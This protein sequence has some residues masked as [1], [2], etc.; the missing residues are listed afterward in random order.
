MNK[1]TS[2]QEWMIH[3]INIHGTFFERWCQ[4]IIGDIRPWTIKS[5]NYPVEYPPASGPFRG[6]E[7]A[8][9][10][11]TEL[12]VGNSLLALIIECKKNNPDFVNWVFFPRHNDATSPILRASRI[13]NL[14]RQVP[15]TGWDVRRN[16][17]Q[18]SSWM[19]LVNESRETR[20]SYLQYTKGDKTKTSNAAISEAAYQVALATQA[21]IT[22][23]VSFSSIRS[24]GSPATSIV[25]VRQIFLPIIVTT[26]RIITCG[27]DPVDVDPRTG[28]IPYD[29]AYIEERPYVLYEYPLPPLLQ[30]YPEDITTLVNNGAGDMYARMHIIVVHSE[31]FA[32]LLTDL[33][34]RAPW[35][36]GE[37]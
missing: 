6:K 20:S 33:A 30:K 34:R 2:D 37:G 3:S 36:L 18:G 1:P 32:E 4:Q 7:S 13:E 12:R 11:R 22:E 17:V 15:A 24:G 10:I 25:Y 27:F 21:V 23:E 14:L 8:L 31:S 28:E 5:S 19:P 9:D 29:K 26:A 35:L 16:L